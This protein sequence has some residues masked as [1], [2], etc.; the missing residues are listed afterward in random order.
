LHVG[1]LLD[2][3]GQRVAGGP[4][5]SGGTAAARLSHRQRKNLGGRIDV[6]ND[7]IDTVV[8]LNLKG[9]VSFT[10]TLARASP[11]HPASP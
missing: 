4:D 2:R 11:A 9:T 10:R 5:S 8:D 1:G 7:D 6:L 3:H